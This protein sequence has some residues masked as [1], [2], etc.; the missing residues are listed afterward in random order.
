MIKTLFILLISF[1]SF[2]GDDFNDC[3]KDHAPRFLEMRQMFKSF[4]TSEV[5]FKWRSYT[6]ICVVVMETDTNINC[7]HMP[8]QESKWLDENFCN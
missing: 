1:Q 4:K 5:S 2:A 7:Q 8:S 3:I 6:E